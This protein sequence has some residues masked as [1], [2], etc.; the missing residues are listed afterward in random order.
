MDAKK[1][2][3]LYCRVNSTVNEHDC[4]EKQK[5]ELMDFAGQMDFEIEGI[6]QDTCNGMDFD[7]NGLAEVSEAVTAGKVSILLIKDLSRLGR[8]MLKVTEFIQQLNEQGIKVY[9][10]EEGE[11]KLGIHDMPVAQDTNALNE[12]KC[13]K[14]IEWPYLVGYV[15]SEE[16]IESQLL[17]V[18]P[19]NIAAFIAK[20]ATLEG[21]DVQITTPL[22]T[23]FLSTYGGFIDYCS[24]QEFLRTELLPALIPMQLGDTEPPEVEIIQECE[25]ELPEDY[26]PQN[27]DTDEQSL[28]L[29]L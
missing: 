29:G 27:V 21:N 8:D 17:R 1:H 24:D 6:S 5:K 10:S 25:Q 4:L 26:N 19:K 23:P 7:R 12:H 2:A 3:W 13:F 28:R 9:S 11:I 15:K 20:N 16:F 22:D 18:T 14:V